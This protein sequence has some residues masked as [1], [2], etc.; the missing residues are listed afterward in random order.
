MSK[1]AKELEVACLGSSQAWQKLRSLKEKMV[2]RKTEI[3]LCALA[4]VKVLPPH[5]LV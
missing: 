4:I 5:P 3:L 1:N 2:L